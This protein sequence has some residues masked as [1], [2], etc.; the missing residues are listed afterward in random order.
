MLLNN[1]TAEK[2]LKLF[3]N[4]PYDCVTY[5]GCWN[6]ETVS[7]EV[8]C[9]DQLKNYIAGIHVTVTQNF[10]ITRVQRLKTTWSTRLKKLPLITEKIPLHPS[11]QLPLIYAL[12]NENKPDISKY[13]I[14][15]NY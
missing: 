10:E 9:V 7:F 14:R 6:A 8:G 15:F 5:A 2:I 11:G 13:G 3:P 4:M 1:E 12:Y